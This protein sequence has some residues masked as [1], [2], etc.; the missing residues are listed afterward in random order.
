MGGGGGMGGGMGGMLN[1]PI[2][3]AALAG[4]AASAVR[5]MMSGR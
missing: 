4:I 2:A 3:K 1:N 5:R